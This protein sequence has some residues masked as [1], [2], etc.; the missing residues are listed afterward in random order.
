MVKLISLYG[1]ECS[2]A[3][4]WEYSDRS[5]LYPDQVQI[6]SGIL[7]S[8][9]YLIC[10]IFRK[11]LKEK[12]LLDLAEIFS[13]IPLH[14][15]QNRVVLSL[16]RVILLETKKSLAGGSNPFARTEPSCILRK[17]SLLEFEKLIVISVARYR[18]GKRKIFLNY[19]EN[20]IEN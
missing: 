5:L 13:N 20:F 9:W 17:L 7:Y 19:C 15:F 6:S 3:S 11:E 16:N 4:G 12:N 8:L 1:R 14:P 10:R 2:I 18:K